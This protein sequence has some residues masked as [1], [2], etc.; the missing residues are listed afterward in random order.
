MLG[1]TFLAACVRR[2]RQALLV[3]A[4]SSRRAAASAPTTATQFSVSV[5]DNGLFLVLAA[6]PRGRFSAHETGAT[7]NVGDQESASVSSSMTQEMLVEIARQV[8]P[9]AHALART[10]RLAA[11]KEANVHVR[12]ELKRAWEALRAGRS[13]QKERAGGQPPTAQ[14]DDEKKPAVEFFDPLSLP[15]RDAGIF[16]A[17]AYGMAFEGRFLDS[18]ASATR[19]FLTKK[20]AFVR[21][22][23]SEPNRQ[24]VC[25]MLRASNWEPLHSASIQANRNRIEIVDA[26]FATEAFRPTFVLCLDH[27]ARRV[28]VSWR[29]TISSGDTATDADATP[30]PFCDGLA[31]RGFV[32]SLL[33]ARVTFGT[34]AQGSVAAS[35]SLTDAIAELLAVNTGYDVLVT[36]HSLGGSLALLSALHIARSDAVAKVGTPKVDAIA[37][38][39]P[40]PFA[41][42]ASTSSSTAAQPTSL[43]SLVLGHDPVP[44]MQ[45]RKI[46]ALLT[47]GR[48]GGAGSSSS[49]LLEGSSL[50]VTYQHPGPVLLLQRRGPNHGASIARVCSESFRP[51]ESMEANSA[52]AGAADAN[53]TWRRLLHPNCM[54]DHLL[55][56]YLS[57]LQECSTE[58]TANGA[59]RASRHQM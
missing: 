30:I 58:R 14:E 33:A 12:A 54:G 48:V 18:V 21:E 49:T 7:A 28:V 45:P 40:P 25:R 19:L 1:T 43:V 2:P 56:R 51:L 4:T 23:P 47:G 36:G 39:P 27:V 41:R 32:L 15:L 3:C 52:N 9:A 17:A 8:P 31:P 20:G 6:K 53:L 38:G 50:A 42:T 37:F 55:G 29:G 34:P 11:T 35:K 57:C 44:R 22:A 59:T 46:A 24:S 16:S 26:V 10:H 5:G 13:P